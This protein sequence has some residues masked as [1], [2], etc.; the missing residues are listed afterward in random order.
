MKTE[1]PRHDMTIEVELTYDEWPMTDGIPDAA[2]T[3]RA[4][5][6]WADVCEWFE[7]LDD[8][9][10]SKALVELLPNARESLAPIL[11]RCSAEELV[12]ELIRRTKQSPS[13][14]CFVARAFDRYATVKWE[15]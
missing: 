15:C 13:E 7:G 11:D 9:E 8:D 1:Y 3:A 4:V 12:N 6:G 10:K 5:L 14:R 2:Y